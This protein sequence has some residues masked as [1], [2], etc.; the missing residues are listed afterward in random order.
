MVSGKA[1]MEQHEGTVELKSTVGSGTEVSVI[2][3]P[4]RVIETA[5]KLAIS[6]VLPRSRPAAPRPAVL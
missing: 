1:I 4:E 5:V 2:F 3:P 6:R